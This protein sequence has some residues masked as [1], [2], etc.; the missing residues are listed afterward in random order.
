[1]AGMAIHQE[2]PDISPGWRNIR[3]SLIHRRDG[4]T[5]ELYRR[6]GDTSGRA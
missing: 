6:D 1:M 3:K 4:D 5:S 2:E